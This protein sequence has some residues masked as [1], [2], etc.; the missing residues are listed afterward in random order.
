MAPSKKKTSSKPK[1]L[2]RS[3]KR[4]AAGPGKP[5]RSVQE[6]AKEPL[7]LDESWLEALL[8]LNQMSGAPIQDIIEFSLAEAVGLTRSKRGYLAFLDMAESV[9]AIHAW[10]KETTKGEQGAD[11]SPRWEEAIR[12]RK[13]VVRDQP[14]ATAS[15]RNNARRMVVP[16]FDG[17]RIVLVAGVEDRE[18]GY[19]DSDV[20]QLTLLMEDMWRLIEGKR[21]NDRIL[22]QTAVLNGINKVIREALTCESEEEVART[23]L[24]VA[25][26]LT[27][28][29]FGF[30]GE[31]NAAGRFDTI[32]LSDPGWSV[33]TL[34]ETEAPRLIRDM[35]IRGIWGKVLE[36]EAPHVTND[37]ASHPDRVGTPEG[38]PPLTSFLGVPL[39]QAGRTIGMIALANKTDGYDPYDVETVTVLAVAFVEALRRKRAEL[40]LLKHQEHLEELVAVRTASLEGMNEQLAQEVAQRKQTEEALTRDR[41]L[42]R[43]L[44]D[45]L[46]DYIFA[47]DADSRF[48]LNN[49]AHIRLLRAAAPEEIYGKTDYDIFPEEL[50]AH[51]YADEQ[52]VI[53]SGDALIN[54]EEEVIDEHGQKHWLLT[55]KVP[56]RDDEGKGIGVVGISRNITERKRMAGALADQTALLRQAN[57]D[58]ER[59]NREL[60]E[61]TFVASHDL[62]EPLRK[63][64]A[65]SD[66]LRDDMA[67]G[68]EDEVQQDLIVITSAAQRMQQ[69]VQDLLALSR[70][71]RQDMNWGET[72]VDHCV[73]RALD[74]LE[75]RVAET[76]AT[77]HRDPLPVV[78]GDPGLL[79]QLFQ[80]LIGNALKFHGEEPPRIRI[81]AH[82]AGGHWSFE[83]ADEGIG[84]KPAYA[85][86][87]F[88][89]FKRLHRRGEYEGTGIGLAICRK[90]VERHDGNIWVES[91]FGKGARFRF[92]IGEQ[93]RGAS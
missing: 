73:D 2:G 38:H 35:V 17:E 43:T 32:T 58:L 22:R 90:I 88:S 60:D 89:P 56:L 46:P 26:E 29:A 69:L 79:T 30:I 41:N 53:R 40:E 74:V 71:G 27:G 31:V 52:A 37:P 12:L 33:C 39:K 6:P 87:I 63:L 36:D 81:T 20:R 14:G 82:D 10:P 67:R 80:N 21:A 9:L 19:D 16:V 86:Q 47:K 50:A 68:D 62:Q 59:R 70:S 3:R 57:A 85:E 93:E 78:Q 13:P 18:R 54:R 76:Q 34:P 65:F 72:S 42:L 91:E 77:I 28:S 23:C 8:K 11:E 4:G 48:I 7:G 61:F 55:T 5:A 75:L 44:I 24:A 45:N 51:Y 25:Q 83:V 66:V 1:A 15:S 64:S 92:T 84:I 49:A